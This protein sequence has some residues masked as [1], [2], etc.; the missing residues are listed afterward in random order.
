MASTASFQS[1]VSLASLVLL[2]LL[3]YRDAFAHLQLNAEH[4][5]PPR[6]V[7]VPRDQAIADKDGRIDELLAELERVQKDNEELEALLQQRDEDVKQH[8]AQTKEASAAE[9]FTGIDLYDAR[10]LLDSDDKAWGHIYPSRVWCS[11]LTMWPE[12]RHGIE[13]V[14]DT[15]APL[16]DRIV[17]VVDNSTKTPE[18]DLGFEFLKLPLLTPQSE[19]ARN[20][21]DKSWRTWRHVGTHHIDEAEWFLKLDDDT[22]FSPV[23]FKGF[24]RYFN[25]DKK[26]YFGYTSLHNWEDYNVV[27][28]TGSCYAISRGALRKLV[29]VFES[30]LFRDASP[31]ETAGV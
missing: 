13:M 22:F 7:L 23:N 20:I 3:V 9:N 19:D 30:H 14:I 4:E 6:P 26:W 31:F 24:A 27:F 1:V 11:V 17:F 15:W 21:W 8:N 16:C 18:Y 12:R 29:P 28:N 5:E 2:M 10:D 25:P